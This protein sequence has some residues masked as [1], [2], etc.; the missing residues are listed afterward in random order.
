MV[1]LH[2]KKGDTVQVISGDDKGKTGVVVKID[3]EKSR[4][5]VEGLNL[6][7]RHKKPTAGDPQSG[8][9]V[10]KEAGIHISNL[11]LVNPATGKGERTGRKENAKGSLQRYFKSNNELVK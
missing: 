4:A 10:K 2:I 7:S 11:L 1:K 3:T 9:I 5:I 6:V 8:G